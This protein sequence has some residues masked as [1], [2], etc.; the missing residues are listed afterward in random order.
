MVPS[1]IDVW[2]YDREFCSSPP[3]PPP[4]QKQ[5]LA[6]SLAHCIKLRCRSE[7]SKDTVLLVL[8]IVVAVGNLPQ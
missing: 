1:I 7:T 2:G 6:S 4:P 8:E 3:P 5:G